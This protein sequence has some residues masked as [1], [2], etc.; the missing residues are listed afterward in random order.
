M[1]CW[2]YHV[3]SIVVS[4]GRPEHACR[5]FGPPIGDFRVSKH[6]QDVSLWDELRVV[7]CNS[8]LLALKQICSV[9]LGFVFVSVVALLSLSELAW[10]ALH[11][12]ALGRT[13]PPGEGPQHHQWLEMI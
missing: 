4:I 8:V 1:G 9:G 3:V 13:R 7:L 10:A 11:F 6:V 5:E 12:Q 2:G